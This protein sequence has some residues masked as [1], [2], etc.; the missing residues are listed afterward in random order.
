MM[1]LTVVVRLCTCVVS[2]PAVIN[3]SRVV[4]ERSVVI[5]NS[6]SLHCPVSGVPQPTVHWLR[7]GQL[8]SSV[9]HPNVRVDNAGH[10]LHVQNMQLVDIGAYTCLASNVAGNDSKQ[11]VLNILGQLL[12]L[13]LIHL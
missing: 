12:I 7:D 8:I 13:H 11:F 2:V 5:G 9:D 4:D 6:V 1:R 10:T 3:D